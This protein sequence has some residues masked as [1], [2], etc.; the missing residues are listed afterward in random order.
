[1]NDRSA[2]RRSYQLNLKRQPEK[3]LRRLSRDLRERIDHKI[4]DLAEDPRPEGS[5]K[6]EGYDNLY[7]L[8]VGDWRI[9]YA[10][11]DDR[12]IVL[13]LEISPRGSAY[14]NLR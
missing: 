10:I 9:S 11:E 7:R 12:L 4:Q 8:R 2:D 1:M 14:R 6:L 3:V 13:I 5:K